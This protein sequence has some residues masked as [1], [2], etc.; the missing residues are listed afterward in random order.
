MSKTAKLDCESEDQQIRF[1]SPEGRIRGD[2]RLVFLLCQNEYHT[3]NRN[4]SHNYVCIFHLRSNCVTPIQIGVT[5]CYPQSNPGRISLGVE[6]RDYLTANLRESSL[7]AFFLRRRALLRL[8]AYAGIA[9]LL[10][11]CYWKNRRAGFP[12]H[13]RLI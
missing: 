10:E 5:R 11:N 4:P 13:N 2:S 9:R 7:I 6:I 1:V 8:I 3:R 12:L